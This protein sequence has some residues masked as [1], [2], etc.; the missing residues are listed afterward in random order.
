[1]NPAIRE[2]TRRGRGTIRGACVLAL[3]CVSATL[4]PVGIVNAEKPQGAIVG[5]GFNSSGKSDA[6]SPNTGFVGIAAGVEHS[7]G[8]KVDGSIVA[9]GWNAQGQTNVPAP[10][11]G[12]V[13]V[14]AG[15]DHSLGLK[16]DGSIVAWGCG[17]PED[18]FGQCRVPSPNTGFVAISAG[19]WHSL[20]L[21]ADGSI[22]GW[23]YN[24]YHQAEPPAP[25]ADFVA[26][27]AGVV[28]S[29]GLRS[30]GSVVAWGENGSGQTNVPSPNSGF[31]AVAG[32][33]AHSLGL[34]A[35]GSIV[36]WGCGG[37][38]DNGQCN[39]PY[40]NSGFVTIQAGSFHS[41]G[42]R[43]DESIVPWGC[44]HPSVNW[45]QCDVP[46]ANSGFVALAAGYAH[47]LAI[48]SGPR[49]APVCGAKLNVA[50]LDGAQRSNSDAV[51]LMI[52]GN[53]TPW[54]T[55][56][57]FAAPDVM[58][59]NAHCVKLSASGCAQID[60]AQLRVRFFNECDS[61]QNGSVSQNQRDV[62]V[63]RIMWVDDEH[64]FALLEIDED[65]AEIYGVLRVT[66]EDFRLGDDCYLIH[67]ASGGGVPVSLVMKG[68]D[69]GTVVGEFD[70]PGSD[71]PPGRMTTVPGV[72]YALWSKGGGFGIPC[73]L[74][75]DRRCAG[76]QQQRRNTDD[77]MQ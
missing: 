18:D 36:A 40:P 9:W 68:F 20:A 70:D 75:D 38:Y 47:S 67:H 50:C 60:P 56:W 26:I 27:A 71:C 19:W 64:D 66:C 72:H 32:G 49:C 10:N 5:W 44:G 73:I 77:G 42:L 63:N 34:K 3:A 14:A 28:H 43:A 13:A 21:K 29:L 51:G 17:A 39:V 31:I 61:C 22:V 59:T 69:G 53:D 54:C 76:D 45:G 33:S 35:D 1:M 16:A 8:L 24:E 25:N 58:I 65:V 55:A 57:V 37:A 6:P 11:T 23:G 48:R 52:F 4:T 74:G 7:L 30:D 12:F 62:G 41:L 15:Q 46:I 2:N